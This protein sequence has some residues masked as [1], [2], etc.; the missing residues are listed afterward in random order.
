MNDGFYTNLGAYLGCRVYA[1]ELQPAC[2]N[3]AITTIRLNNLQSKIRIFNYAVSDSE[4][5]LSI[6]L[7]KNSTICRGR[8]SFTRSD[9]T[10]LL[11]ISDVRDRGYV[12]NVTAVRLDKVVPSTFQID[13]L[14]IDTEGHDPQVLLGAEELFRNKQ[15]RYYCKI[16]NL[17]RLFVKFN[18]V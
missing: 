15:I 10:D 5:V 17:F 2:I 14:K 11:P 1:F 3:A 18:L 4:D 12:T 16:I 13:L 9:L 8:F 7:A 6:P